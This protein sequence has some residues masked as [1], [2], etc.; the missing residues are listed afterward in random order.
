MFCIQK[1]QEANVFYNLSHFIIGQALYTVH[2]LL[3]HQVR[4]RRNIEEEHRRKPKKHIFG[5]IL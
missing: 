4:S 1:F 2:K 3:L 5:K